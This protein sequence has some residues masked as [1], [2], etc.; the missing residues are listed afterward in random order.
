FN[1]QI[2]R[3]MSTTNPLLESFETAPFS[4]IRPEHFRPAI[5]TAIYT[6]KEEIAAITGNQ[7]DPDFENTVEAL[8]F[9]GSQLDRITS[10]FFNLNS[11]ETN[12]QIQEIA[13]EISP[14]LSDFKNDIILNKDLFE[15]VQKVYEQKDV[16][17]LNVEQQTL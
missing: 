10:I 2:I 6:A 9:A 5:E 4:E 16:L 1:N 13:Q 11:A 7:K 12:D 15:K 17:D 8:E 3:A 14:I